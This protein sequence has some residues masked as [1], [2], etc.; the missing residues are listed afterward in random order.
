MIRINI[1]AAAFKT[2]VAT[3]PLG[4]VACEVEPPRRTT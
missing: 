4:S 1:T 2:I 3:M